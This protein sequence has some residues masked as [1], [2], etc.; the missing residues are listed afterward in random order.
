VEVTCGGGG[1][2]E[3]RM[4]KLRTKIDRMKEKRKKAKLKKK[5]MRQATTTNPE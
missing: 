5:Q 3:Q 2:G 4:T 1:K